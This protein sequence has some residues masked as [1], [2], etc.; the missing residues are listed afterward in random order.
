M[1]EALEQFGEYVCSQTLAKEIS[2]AEELDGTEVE[3]K[4]S[5]IKIAVEKV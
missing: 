1:K 5:T 4:D 3:W 2:Q